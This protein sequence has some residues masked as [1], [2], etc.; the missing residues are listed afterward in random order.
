MHYNGFSYIVQPSR[1]Q[2]FHNGFSYIV[3]PSRL[4]HFHRYTSKILLRINRKTQNVFSYFRSSRNEQ[5]KIVCNLKCSRVES[6]QSV[7]SKTRYILVF[8]NPTSHGYNQLLTHLSLAPVIKKKHWT[9]PHSISRLLIFGQ[10]SH[11]V[12]WHIS[13]S[14]S[15]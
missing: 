14:T 8:W 5:H 10:I 7:Y 12:V 4:Q 1:L 2:H 15:K 6:S 9:F 3:Q 11:H 13:N